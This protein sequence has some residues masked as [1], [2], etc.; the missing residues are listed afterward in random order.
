MKHEQNIEENVRKLKIIL[1]NY[2]RMDRKTKSRLQALGFEIHDSQ[3]HYKITFPG[4][5]LIAVLGKTPS[6]NRAGK[7]TFRYCKQQLLH[8]I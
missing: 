2:T 1:R 5:S 6:C 7:N 3:T 8:C 4:S